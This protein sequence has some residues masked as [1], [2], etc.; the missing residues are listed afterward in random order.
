MQLIKRETGFTKFAAFECHFV[1]L[2]IAAQVWSMVL[3]E[4]D[5]APEAAMRS[6]LLS[7][8][9]LVASVVVVAATGIV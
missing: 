3:R 2:Y 4:W 6:N 5:G 1:P 8:A 7:L 9:L